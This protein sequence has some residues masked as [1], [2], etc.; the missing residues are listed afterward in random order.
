MTQASRRRPSHTVLVAHPSAELYGSDRVMLES[1][2]GL[3]DDGWRV[4]VTVPSDGPLLSELRARGASVE[5]CPSPVLRKSVLTPR[6][7]ARFV[8]T[9]L[10]STV[11]GMSLLRRERPALVYVSTITVPL[12]PVLARLV[13]VPVLTHVHEGEA[14]A[15]RL[16]RRLL[17][18]PLF[19]SR[20]LLVN[21]RFSA[22]VLSTSFE[23]L[24]RR[25]Q[26]VYN[27]VP[28]PSRRTP[29]RETLSGPLRVTYIGRLSPRKGVDVAVDA[30]A[31]L[32]DRGVH[33]ELDVVGS[34]FPGYE[35]YQEELA[36][37]VGSKDLGG[38][39]RFHGFQPS[40][41]DIVG[42]GDVV[43]VPS[44]V[45]EPFGNTAVEALLAAR[46]VIASATSGLLE[47]TAGYQ[48]AVTVQPDDAGALADALERTVGDWEATA[49]A[50][51][52]DAAAAERRHSVATYRS[53]I[54]A[55]ARA[56]A[57]R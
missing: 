22:G 44:R 39:V 1:V 28:G 57:R 26:V 11:H 45:D 50:V 31:R 12:W 25:A 46:P 17:A 47:A 48:A 27:A 53:R 9:S 29:P 37:T 10:S 41:W 8:A 54:A 4:V 32:R 36:S 6:G 34:V 2:S 49:E 14:S 51:T 23:S 19:L 16:M 24:G 18:L 15:S 30:V 5:L 40:V 35:W 38:R 7:F 21:S 43:V 42:S 33:A 52:S 3:V 13:G 56:T 20:T 55:V